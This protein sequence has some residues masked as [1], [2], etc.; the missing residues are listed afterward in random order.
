MG[1]KVSA[2]KVGRDPVVGLVEAERT[3]NSG[4]DQATDSLFLQGLE[5]GLQDNRR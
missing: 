3:C 1:R 5:G 4:S 2:G